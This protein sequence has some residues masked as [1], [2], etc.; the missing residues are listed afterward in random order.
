MTDLEE[1]KV[2]KALAKARHEASQSCCDDIAYELKSIF[3]DFCESEHDEM[4]VELG[5]IY[6]NH[7]RNVFKVLRD[8]GVKL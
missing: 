4:D 7:L 3:A 6:R 2:N 8:K 1:I 5:E